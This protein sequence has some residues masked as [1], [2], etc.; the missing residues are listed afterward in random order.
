MVAA[1]GVSINDFAMLCIESL[2]HRQRPFAG[3]PASVRVRQV[4]SPRVGSDLRRPG[5]L[6]I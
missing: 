2:T 1:M 4:G 5:R 3:D 6:P